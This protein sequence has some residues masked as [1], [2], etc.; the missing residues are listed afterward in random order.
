[1]ERRILAGSA[2]VE[3]LIDGTHDYSESLPAD[4]S[5]AESLAAASN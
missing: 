4:N 3:F 5:E 2:A 1:M